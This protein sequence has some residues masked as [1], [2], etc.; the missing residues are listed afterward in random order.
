VSVYAPDSLGSF[1][2]RTYAD[3]RG[4]LDRQEP[5]PVHVNP[6]SSSDAVPVLWPEVL[7]IDAVMMLVFGGSG[8]ALLSGRIGRDACSG[9]DRRRYGVSPQRAIP[10]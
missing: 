9:R 3:L 6:A 2:D 5:V 1:F 7:A 4:H 8:L 10:R